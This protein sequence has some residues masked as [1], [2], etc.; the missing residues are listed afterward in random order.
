ML[1]KRGIV[2]GFY[3]FGIFGML[4]IGAGCAE[5]KRL[6]Q[7][8][9]QLNE[10]VSGL[11]QENA[12]LSS[13]IGMYEHE[14]SRLENSRRELEAKLK[15]TGATTRIKNGAVS[16]SLPG[17]ILFD[18]GKTTLRPQSKATLRKI[19]QVLKSEVPNEI[20]RIEGHT[21]NE[22]INKQKDKYKSNWELSAARA[23]A[24]LHYMV[25]E[26]GVSPT[27]VYIAGFGQ[28]Q[29]VSDNRSKTGKAKNRR[30]EFVIVPRGGG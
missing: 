8:N 7:E 10:N 6:R 29:P 14:L 5:T 26:C 11:Q 15:G 25:E 19:S 16:I 18:S 13:K 9:Q 28:Y 21:D 1:G 24:V 17:T 20:V 12:E 23:T 27:K 30:V 2:R 3:L 22:P 4:A